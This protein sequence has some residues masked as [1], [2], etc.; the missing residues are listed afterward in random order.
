MFSANATL[1]TAAGAEK[2][3]SARRY[4]PLCKCLFVFLLQI[5]FKGYPP[6]LTS[7]KEGQGHC[8]QNCP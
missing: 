6:Y 8:G 7:P 1:R 2:K 3:A 4:I 5:F